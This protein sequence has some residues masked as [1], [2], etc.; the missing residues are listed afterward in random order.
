L[1]PK[2]L[3]EVR[4][5]RGAALAAELARIEQTL[6]AQGKTSPLAPYLPRVQAAQK[7][8]LAPLAGLKAAT[9]AQVQAGNTL[10]KAKHDWTLAYDTVY[11]HLRALFPGKKTVVE[12][13]F[14]AVDAPRKGKAAAPTEPVLA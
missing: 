3:G 2:G 12:S 14:L 7:D 9:A 5:L 6:A 1:F 4:R 11:G 8:W 10:D 13:Y